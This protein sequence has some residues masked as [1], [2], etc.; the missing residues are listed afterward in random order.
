MGSI[1]NFFKRRLTD[2]REAEDGWNIPAEKTW[3]NVS[4][5]LPTPKKKYRWIWIFPVIF[6]GA[7]LIFYAYNNYLSTPATIAIDAPLVSRTKSEI[8][9][10]VVVSPKDQNVV[11]MTEN[12]DNKAASK[13]NPNLIHIKNGDSQEKHISKNV[14]VPF[15]SIT[16]AGTQ[17]ETLESKQSN[18]NTIPK[19]DN[20]QWINTSSNNDRSPMAN[21]PQGLSYTQ[22]SSVSN[23]SDIASSP[24]IFRLNKIP[25]LDISG[26]ESRLEIP[27]ISTSPIF[28]I[29]ILYSKWELGISLSTYLGSKPYTIFDSGDIPDL[30]SIFTKSTYQG[31]NLHFNKK[32]NNRWSISTGMNFS[33]QK[34]YLNF[35]QKHVW[36]ATNNVAISRSSNFVLKDNLNLFFFDGIEVSNGQ[37]LCLQGE[38]GAEVFSLRIP[39]IGSYHIY[40]GKHEY[41]LSFGVSLGVDRFSLAEGEFMIYREQQLIGIDLNPTIDGGIIPQASAYG[42]IGYRYHLNDKWK[43]GA[44]IYYDKR[45]GLESYYYRSE[46]GV[47]I[48]I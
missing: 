15:H 37:E 9:P 25:I 24:L 6:L 38:L 40:Q 30:E 5:H 19:N 26:L 13:S 10:P 23:N 8:N 48:K 39:V 32:L 3:E 46:I 33:H 34:L 4:T 44:S 2:Y 14:M 18:H 42:G 35:T 47:F 12:R 36:D 27:K 28:D 20:D 22:K 17:Y 45:L 31:L 11:G 21:L 29:P 43:I 16:Q 41:L 1:D 7:V